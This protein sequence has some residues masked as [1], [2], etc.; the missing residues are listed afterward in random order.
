[1]HLRAICPRQIQVADC[2]LL[3]KL[4]VHLPPPSFLVF[5][6]HLPSQLQPITQFIIRFF[7]CRKKVSFS[8]IGA[9][10]KRGDRKSK[11]FRIRKS[12]PGIQPAVWCIPAILFW[13]DG[14]NA[15]SLLMLC[16]STKWRRGRRHFLFGRSTKT[17][18][19]LEWYIRRH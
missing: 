6:H 12:V 17:G 18:G 14:G 1:M 2:L 10:W 7:H 16:A 11:C 8:C 4:V 13:G 9:A 5:N 3:E 19:D 15:M